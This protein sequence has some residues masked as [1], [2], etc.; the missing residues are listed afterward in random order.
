MRGVRRGEDGDGVD[1]QGGE[2]YEHHGLHEASCRDIRPVARTGDREGRGQWK[3]KVRHDEVRQRA[4]QQRLRDPAVP[5]ADSQG[6]SRDRDA[7]RDHAVLH[8]DP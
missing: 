1:R 4:G 7:S 6:R 8:D 5:G 2:P 3:D